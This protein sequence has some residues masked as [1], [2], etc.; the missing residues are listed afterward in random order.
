[1]YMN[2]F[3]IYILGDKP[4]TIIF[5]EKDKESTS[6]IIYSPYTIYQD[7]TI[8]TLKNKIILTLDYEFS[9][10]EIYLFSKTQMILKKELLY[11]LLF[12]EKDDVI[13]SRYK[14]LFIGCEEETPIINFDN[15]DEMEK[16]Y[17]LNSLLGFSFYKNYD[18]LFPINPYHASQAIGKD[19]L[20]P[21]DNSLLL[22]F[23]ILNNEIYMCTFED[24]VKSSS[25]DQASIVNTYFPLL[26]R[27]QIKTLS[28]FH[29]K[30]DD[31]IS[32]TKKNI[33]K[34][35]LKYYDIVDIL[36]EISESSETFDSENNG[37]KTFQINIS[38]KYEG[39]L[40][41]HAVFKNIHASKKVPM[42]K[43]S[44][45]I[46]RESMYRLYCEN[47]ALNGS[48]I[49]YLSHQEITKYNKEIIVRNEN[50]SLLVKDIIEGE[51]FIIRLK[52]NGNI[53]I[54]FSFKTVINI[55]KVEDILTREVNEIL[56]TIND[57]L[58]NIGY[59]ISLF[60]GLMDSSVQVKNIEHE[61]EIKIDKKVDI[62]KH[63]NL[64]FPLFLIK[65]GSIDNGMDLRFKRV[66]NYK[67][68][69]EIE[70]FIAVEKNGVEAHELITKVINHFGLS[71]VEA[72]KEVI[73]FGKTFDFDN[74]D[75]FIASGFPVTMSL[76]KSENLLKIN[77]RQISDI[78]FLH[79]L[80]DYY[81]G[82]VTFF[83]KPHMISEELMK[84]IEKLTKKEIN[85]KMIEK[86]IIKEPIV[87]PTPVVDEAKSAE[88]QAES[89][90]E[91][92]TEEKEDDFEEDEFFGME[93]DEDEFFG[94]DEDDDEI[95][96][97]A[98]E[99][100]SELNIDGMK[101][102]NPN[103]FQDRIERRDSKLIVKSKKELKNKKYN[104]YSTTC[105]ANYL[106]QP[107]ILNENEMKTIDERDEEQK[108]R[109]YTKSMQFGS[110]DSKKHWYICPR[111]WS[112]KHNLS[113]SE[114]E[115][116]DILEKEP[117]A[118]IPHDKATVPKGSYIF[119]FNNAKE[120]IKDGK[121]IPHYPGLIMDKHPDGYGIPCCFKTENKGLKEKKEEVKSSNYVVDPNKYPLNEDRLGMISDNIA[122]F[123]KINNKECVGSNSM[124]KKNKPCLLRY[125]VEQNILK[126]FIGCIAYIYH[127]FQLK[128]SDPV[129][130]IQEMLD[131]IIDVVS[132]DK[133][134]TYQNGSLVSLFKP[135]VEVD[136]DIEPYEDTKFY[137]L[138]IKESMSF[139]KE[140][141][142]AY[143]NFIE[144]LKDPNS[145]VDHTYLWDIICSKNTKLIPNGI[146]LVILNDNSETSLVNIVC[147]TN[148]YNDVL[149]DERLKTFFILKREDFYEPL[150]LYEDK[151]TSYS[152][153]STFHYGDKFM[154]DTLEKVKLKI[155]TYCTPKKSKNTGFEMPVN[156]E[157]MA[158]TLQKYKIKINS[159]IMN[160]QAK[161]IGALV[162][163]T[164]SNKKI[165]CFIP[166]YP[167]SFVDVN[168]DDV[169]LVNESIWT[170]YE[171]TKKCLQYIQE[172]TENKI[173][174]APVK[175]VLKD[176]FVIGF[177]TNSNLF[178]KI[179]QPIMNKESLDELELDF[180][181][182]DE[183][184]ADMDINIVKHRNKNQEQLVK[185]IEFENDYYSAF[186]T[187]MRILL[188]NFTNRKQKKEIEKIIRSDMK[189]EQKIKSL[190]DIFREISSDYIVFGY[191]NTEK[192]KDIGTCYNKCENDSCI[193]RKEQCV[194]KIPR[195]NLLQPNLLNYILY[196]TK[197]ADEMVRIYR[198]R[199]FILEPNKY[200]NM[201][202]Y[203]YKVNP[204]E[205][206]LLDSFIKAEYFNELE[207][208]RTN[209]YIHN[210][211]YDKAMV[212]KKTRKVYSNKTTF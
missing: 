173:T 109:S 58:E 209:D 114:E 142:C 176:N 53:S 49:P 32:D 94:M 105:A 98:G 161:I 156:I 13:E 29:S 140:T 12:D 54:D 134:I 11:Q 65:S 186:R 185:H 28:N 191:V 199:S 184:I 116:K 17:I 30:R 164:I 118:I 112:L 166:C 102:K 200:L 212:D 177:K 40:P 147:P 72:R 104:P 206:L 99:L 18:F 1:M 204:D 91:K 66:E 25:L 86:V 125:G 171:D 192:I 135:K 202:S 46:K 44:P 175:K 174:C 193:Q 95:V 19:V 64:F 190:Y 100:E 136:V 56:Q 165:N 34:D 194:L 179:S 203:D 31:L 159:L 63:R 154:K 70:E 170:T 20:E 205:V 90:E 16:D 84:K 79:I 78:K 74:E 37:L 23:P 210:I 110:D 150:C 96:G 189:Y 145:F 182:N 201:S 133:F 51:T 2:T 141:I 211:N 52:K 122:G 197:L 198:I 124:L 76:K 47:I 39:L 115:V 160:F 71:D 48:K 9:Y 128:P 81:K 129:P 107:V 101:L 15:L 10:G 14:T 68:L 43:Y 61:L 155:D 42:I 93:D 75:V 120:H 187:T 183:I 22:N 167:S 178:I 132:I 97:G 196:H 143:E 7:D 181:S 149:F 137:S 130:R 77:T 41:L 59:K 108:K 117:N 168:I 4:K 169:R 36:H 6:K 87:E 45:G 26:A 138:T 57:A 188:N 85:E 148:P 207:L 89:K 33:P 158:K 82:I 146:N 106:R 83:Q 139:L 126:S 38:N 103:P 121:Y 119:E 113:L 127:I 92:S 62:S 157:F 123:F 208:F 67:V 55:E 60:R 151:K 162:M 24:V 152:S 35:L 80:E 153:Q 180:D 163:V 5:G 144:Y 172:Q 195:K 131:I 21:K 3:K 69:S 8:Q 111:Y 88:A 27:Y 73:H 50:I